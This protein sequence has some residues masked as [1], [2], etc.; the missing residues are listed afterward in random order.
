MKLIFSWGKVDVSSGTVVA[1]MQPWLFVPLQ[2]I[3]VAVVG[4]QLITK[5]HKFETNG[6]V[7]GTDG[8]GVAEVVFG[9]ILLV[10]HTGNHELWGYIVD[11]EQ[12]GIYCYV[13][14]R[15]SEI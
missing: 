8:D 9:L 12:G 13:T 6:G 1:N 4:G 3:G 7:A 10:A 15:I 2:I 11:V 5:R 14:A